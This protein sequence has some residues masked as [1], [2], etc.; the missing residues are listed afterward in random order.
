MLGGSLP[1]ALEQIIYS[2]LIALALFLN[3]DYQVVDNPICFD[4]LVFSI[5][6]NHFFNIWKNINITDYIILYYFQCLYEDYYR[7]HSIVYF[8]K[9]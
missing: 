9:N 6:F 8:Y 3:Y 7:P 1:W 4:F 5:V 2:S